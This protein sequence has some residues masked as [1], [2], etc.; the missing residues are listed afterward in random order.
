[1]NKVEKKREKERNMEILDDFMKE[2][3]FKKLSARFFIYAFNGEMFGNLKETDNLGFE[4]EFGKWKFTITRSMR[5]G[6]PRLTKEQQNK[7]VVNAYLRNF[8]QHN[9]F[10]MG[11]K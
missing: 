11:G 3:D 10:N 5:E 1:M 7:M 6:K 8:A 4:F 2:V 9:K